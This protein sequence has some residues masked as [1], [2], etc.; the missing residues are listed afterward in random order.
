[1]PDRID[2]MLCSLVKEMPSLP[3]YLFEVKWDG[4]R[5]VSYVKSGKVRMDSRSG[6]NYTAKYPPVERALKSLR[7]DVVIDGEVV[8]FNEE[9]KPD[10]DALQKYNGHSME[11][12]VPVTTPFQFRLTRS[13]R[14]KLTSKSSFHQEVTQNP[15][16]W[17]IGQSATEWRGLLQRILQSAKQ[18]T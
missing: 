17:I 14:S 18:T 11:I 13:F 4:Y 2:P 8:V 6:L 10:F 16:I 1:M 15:R 9:G 5:I 7:H 12:M 3:D